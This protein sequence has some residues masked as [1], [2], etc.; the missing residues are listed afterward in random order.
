M[1]WS[2]FLIGSGL[3]LWGVY[4]G[5]TNMSYN[6]QWYRIPRVIYRII[7]GEVI[8]GPLARGL[9]VTLEVTLWSA[10]IAFAVGLCTALLRLSRSW[11]GH[12][13]ATVYLE[14]IRNTPLLVQMYLFYFVLSPILGIERFWTGVLCLAFF[15][16]SFIAE[17]IRGGYS[18]C[19]QRPMGRRQLLR[20]QHP[21]GIRQG[22]AA[23]I[24][25]YHAA[26]ADISRGQ[27]DKKLGHRLDNRHI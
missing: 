15:E 6:W 2:L 18:L 23:S 22:R 27:L 13:L 3:V 1:D 7:D 20:P 4:L 12:L 25:P 24:C 17:I 14:L 26:T 5:A 9:L 21:A 8:W 10:L 19:T 16:A 11:A